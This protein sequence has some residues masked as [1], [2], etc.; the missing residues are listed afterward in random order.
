VRYLNKCWLVLQDSSWNCATA[1]STWASVEILPGGTTLAFYLSFSGCWR[2]NVDGGSQNASPILHRKKI[3]YVTARVTKIALRWQQLIFFHASF[4]TVWKLHAFALSAVTVSLH[5]LP[6]MSANNCQMYQNVCYRNLKW[7]FE[8]LLPCYRHAM[9]TNIRT[10]RLQVSQ[11]ASA[12]KWV[13]MSEL[14]AHH[15]ITPGQ[16][17]S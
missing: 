1:L 3:S 8:Y 15:C 10:I 13:D 11:P 4:D 2:Y 9:K 7:T 14:Q 6:Y 5:L 16:W 12:D 17:R